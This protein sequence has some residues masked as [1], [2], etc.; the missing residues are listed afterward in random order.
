MK[1]KTVNIRLLICSA[2]AVAIVAAG[3]VLLVHL[4]KPEPARVAQSGSRKIA[5]APREFEV[6]SAP[7]THIGEGLATQAVSSLEAAGFAAATNH[8][9]PR[10]GG[11]DAPAISTNKPAGGGKKVFVDPVAREALGLVGV[12]PDAEQYWFEALN[13]PALPQTER[14]DLIDDL[15]EQGLADPKHP[16]LDELPM[17]LARI[18]LLEDLAPWMPEYDW[19]EPYRDLEQLIRVIMGSGEEIN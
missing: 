9:Y 1:S 16:S 4:Q 5:P 12:D 18:E 19:D 14:Q 7:E 10:A 11:R 3:V 8:S 17:L 15:N 6:A 2:L 13:N